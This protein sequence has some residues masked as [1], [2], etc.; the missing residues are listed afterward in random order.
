M[1]QASGD[2]WNPR[3]LIDHH[4]GCA[5]ELL[6]SSMYF[7]TVSPED[8]VW[9]TITG[10]PDDAAKYARR[11]TAHFPVSVSLFRNGVAEMDWGGLYFEDADGFE[12]GAVRHDILGIIDRRG[13]AVVKFRAYS[14]ITSLDELWRE[15]E[16]AVKK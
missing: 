4:A 11:L 8:V 16:K 15:A 14:S 7:L 3:F 10:L 2:F 1:N 13:R 6:D 12:G 5:Y 9:N